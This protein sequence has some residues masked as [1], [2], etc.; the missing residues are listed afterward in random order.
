MA[1]NIKTGTG[2]APAG[3]RQDSAESAGR[4][5]HSQ[6]Y[7]PTLGEVWPP[8][9]FSRSHIRRRDHLHVCGGAGSVSSIAWPRRQ[10]PPL[11]PCLNR[12]DNVADAA[13]L[14]SAGW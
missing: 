12:H 2:L 4:Q 5:A 8:G 7:S 6:E 9:C 13:H 11:A 1:I 10:Q 3:S 14:D